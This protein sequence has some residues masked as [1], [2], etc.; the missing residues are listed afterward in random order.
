MVP[1]MTQSTRSFAER[2]AFATTFG[3]EHFIQDAKPCGP[4]AM[5]L[6]KPVAGQ[7]VVVV[8]EAAPGELVPGTWSMKITK[9]KVGELMPM[10]RTMQAIDSSAFVYNHETGV[11]SQ[12]ASTLGE[13][14]RP[15]PM[16]DD[17][18]D[19]GIAIRSVKTDRV[20]RYYLAREI[21]AAG[22]IQG[23]EFRPEKAG[24]QARNK[25]IMRTKVVIFND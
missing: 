23:W 18:V 1:M 14:G 19:V 7:L 15:K 17:A 9:T 12:E 6:R 2:A 20:V 25:M 10:I 8:V 5:F 21:K 3:I 16:Y 13:L 24:D 4:F 22:E 11:F